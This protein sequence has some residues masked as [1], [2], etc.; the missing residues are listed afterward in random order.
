MP[1]PEPAVDLPQLEEW[2]IDRLTVYLDRAPHEID[3]STALADYGLDSVSALGLCGDIEDRF[4]FDVEPTVAYDY[5]TVEAVAGYLAER[6]AE[7]ESPAG[8]AR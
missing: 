5:P 6:L 8:G 7:R 2:L 4:Q 3:A 1:T